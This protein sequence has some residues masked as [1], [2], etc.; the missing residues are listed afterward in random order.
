[1]APQALCSLT[2]VCPTERKKHALNFR[3]GGQAAEVA[4]AKSGAV[5]KG[6]ICGG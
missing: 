2:Q 5:R 1:M 4:N 6:N 3:A